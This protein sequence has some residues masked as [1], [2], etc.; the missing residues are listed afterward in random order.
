MDPKSD[1][2]PVS[3]DEKRGHLA[4]VLERLSPPSLGPSSGFFAPIIVVVVMGLACV[5]P[6]CYRSRPDCV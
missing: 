2:I 1:S 5:G 3:R 4:N 6:V